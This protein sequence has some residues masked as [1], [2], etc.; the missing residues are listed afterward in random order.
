M[1]NVNKKSNPLLFHFK[2][3]SGVHNQVA[4]FRGR[5]DS[6]T[7]RGLFP[8]PLRTWT[9]VRTLCFISSCSGLH[10]EVLQAAARNSPDTHAKSVQGCVG[11]VSCKASATEALISRDK[12][13]MQDRSQTQIGLDWVGQGTGVCT[14]CVW[15]YVGVHTYLAAC[16]EM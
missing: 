14:V 16:A 5:V 11:V 12:R 8:E 10:P 2:Q 9:G 1:W 7:F 4:V 3:S 13:R 6:N 15:K